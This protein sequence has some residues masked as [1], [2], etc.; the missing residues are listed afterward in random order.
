MQDAMNVHYEEAAAVSEDAN[1]RLDA[2]F[3]VLV[4]RLIRRHSV[5]GKT[6]K[7]SDVEPAS[8]KKPEPLTGDTGEISLK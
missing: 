6:G 1:L 2:A 3:D 7:H 5:E 8:N 4:E